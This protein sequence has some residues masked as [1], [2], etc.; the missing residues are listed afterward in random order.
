[1]VATTTQEDEVVMM[2]SESKNNRSRHT[3]N[4]PLTST[5]TTQFKKMQTR[6]TKPDWEALI[7]LQEELEARGNKEIPEMKELDRL[8]NRNGH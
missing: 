1:M 6:D 7:K 5:T 2:T 8:N 4:N 3:T